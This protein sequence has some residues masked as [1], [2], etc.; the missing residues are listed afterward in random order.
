MH[1][2]WCSPGK[3]K[4]SCDNCFVPNPRRNYLASLQ[5]L[6]SG[7]QV[8]LQ[9]KPLSSAVRSHEQ[10]KPLLHAFVLFVKVPGFL[11]ILNLAP[12]WDPVSRTFVL[13]WW[14]RNLPR[15]RLIKHTILAK[16]FC[17]LMPNFQETTLN[18]SLNREFQK[19]GWKKKSV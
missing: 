6:P 16:C 4:E 13:E 10:N 2:L 17:H 9:T 7:W 8:P 12:Q 11:S 14:W 5:M 19:N 18:L 1:V 15:Y 3:L